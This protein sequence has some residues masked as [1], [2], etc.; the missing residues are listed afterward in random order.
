MD[1]IA[2]LLNGHADLSSRSFVVRKQPYNRGPH[3]WSP[4]GF[5]TPHKVQR[6]FHETGRNEIK[7]GVRITVVDPSDAALQM[8]E[9][10]LGDMELIENI[11]QGHAHAQIPATLLAVSTSAFRIEQ[12][13][14]ASGDRIISGAFEAGFDA[15][16]CIVTVQTTL[17]RLDS[18]SL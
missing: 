15:S 9:K 1:A 16:S 14:V 11:F 10:H 6:K 13:D 5:V 3:P 17:N 12:T 7:F 2:E 8:E 4:G 18:S